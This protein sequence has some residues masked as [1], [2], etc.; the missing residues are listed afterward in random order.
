MLKQLSVDRSYDAFSLKSR[1]IR[2][3]SGLSLGDLVTPGDDPVDVV[4]DVFVKKELPLKVCHESLIDRGLTIVTTIKGNSYP[5]TQFFSRFFSEESGSNEVIQE[6]KQKMPGF[7]GLKPPDHHFDTIQELLTNTHFGSQRF[8]VMGAFISTGHTKCMPLPRLNPMMAHWLESQRLTP[9]AFKRRYSTHYVREAVMGASFFGVIRM[10]AKSDTHSEFRQDSSQH[11]ND[12]QS[13]CDYLKNEEINV[14][15]ACQGALP[16]NS[17]QFKAKT[18]NDQ[19]VQSSSQTERPQEWHPGQ[20]FT[21]EGLFN[22]YQ[23]FMNA[24]RTD[25][26]AGYPIALRLAPIDT[27]PE[28]FQLFYRDKVMAAS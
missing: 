11:F 5:S 2:A 7:L 24:I 27:I 12:I 15:I 16:L 3:E 19:F 26:H 8:F 1:E 28:V 9:E 20:L 21:S 14:S 23:E 4:S 10:S 6:I 22:V 18:I 25:A 17:L 13:L